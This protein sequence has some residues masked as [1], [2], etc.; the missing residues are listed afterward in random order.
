MS[1]TSSTEHHPSM[2][3]KQISPHLHSGAY[4]CI[5]NT[6]GGLQTTFKGSPRT[7]STHQTFSNTNNCSLNT[8]VVSVHYPSALQTPSNVLK[9][10]LYASKAFELLPQIS[11]ASKAHE[12]QGMKSQRIQTSSCTSLAHSKCLAPY[13]SDIVLSPKRRTS[14]KSVCREFK[15]KT[16]RL[17]KALTNSLTF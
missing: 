4:T 10:S 2:M 8:F 9:Q 15:H 14:Q 12:L 17:L 3:R 7:S 6:L 1:Y 11:C 5:T 13:M 16:G